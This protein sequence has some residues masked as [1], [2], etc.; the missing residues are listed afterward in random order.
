MTQEAQPGLPQPPQEQNPDFLARMDAE[1]EAFNAAQSAETDAALQEILATSRERAFTAQEL[2]AEAEAAHNAQEQ[3]AAR[4]AA[5]KAHIENNPPVTRRHM[6][7]V[8]ADAEQ[9]GE[10]A[11]ED[12]AWE[13]ESAQIRAEY[14]AQDKEAEVQ[15]ELSKIEAGR[16]QRRMDAFQS[17]LTEGVKGRADAKAMLDVM[18]REGLDTGNWAPFHQAYDLLRPEDRSLYTQYLEGQPAMQELEALEAERAK[19]QDAAA[20]AAEKP[21]I[22]SPFLGLFDANAPAGAPAQPAAPPRPR[23]RVPEP[24]VTPSPPTRPVEPQPA[25]PQQPAGEPVRARAQVPADPPAPRPAGAAE[26]SPTENPYAG[27]TDEQ[28]KN[29]WSD[30]DAYFDLTPEQRRQVDYAYHDRF[31][32]HDI[33]DHAAHEHGQPGNRPLGRPLGNGRDRRRVLSFD[34]LEDFDLD[35]RP[36]PQRQFEELPPKRTPDTTSTHARGREA[37]GK[38]LRGALGFLLT[39]AVVSTPSDYRTQDDPYSFRQPVA[40]G[41]PPAQPLYDTRFD[42]SALLEAEEDELNRRRGRI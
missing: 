3:E 1:V 14:R 31:N 33:E 37:V 23:P 9:A 4:A 38:L 11:A 34:D 29:L 35:R 26:A 8:V 36:A 2:N 16:E 13:Q 15:E 28:L 41:R 30:G 24:P 7:Q 17:A 5:K 12:K 6:W 19:A 18:L 25:P 27:M 42:L 20:S 39:G 21:E 10:N 32:G 40:G 22:D